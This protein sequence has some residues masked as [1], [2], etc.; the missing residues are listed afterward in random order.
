MFKGGVPMEDRT[1]GVVDCDKAKIM[2]GCTLVCA[3]LETYLIDSDGHVVHE[4]RSER[5]VFAAYL[6]P[7]GNL[8]RDGS[9]ND[10]AVAFRAGGAA[11]WVEE[12]TWDN[13]VVW[14]HACLPY[15]SHLTHHDLEP[16]PNGNVLVLCWER[17][18][19]AQALQAGRRVELIPD[20]EVWNNLTLELEPNVAEGG[21]SVVWR[22]SLW[23]H[24]VQDYDET[25]DNYVKDIADHP[26]RFDI[27]YCPPGAQAASIVTGSQLGLLQ[28]A[29]A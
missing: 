2:A 9:E 29:L 14:S 16:L 1:V 4:W 23:D 17:K 21:A 18:T 15:D 11:G 19:K 20:G 22:R 6:L 7:S 13:E 5:P 24:L 27:N 12:V 25:K 10:V 26:A 8:L 28:K 3:G